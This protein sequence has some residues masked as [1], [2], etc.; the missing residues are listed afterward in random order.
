[1]KRGEAG[2]GDCAAAS[3]AHA[4]NIANAGNGRGGSRITPAVSAID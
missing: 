2:G 1:M 3:T 4:T